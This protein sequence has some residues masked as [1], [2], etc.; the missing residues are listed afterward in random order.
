MHDSITAETTKLL[1]MDRDPGAA[2]AFGEMLGEP[3]WSCTFVGNLAGALKS[4]KTS[5]PCAIIV[6]TTANQS[7]N[8]SEF[9]CDH[10]VRVLRQIHPQLP[11]VITAADWNRR[12]EAL[13]DEFHV[14]CLIEPLDAAELCAAL[15]GCGVGKR[16]AGQMP[17]DREMCS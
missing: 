7:V 2:A 6:R 17:S 5:P 1:I 8:P 16:A 12:V 9:G 13:R 4:I 10:I 11:I 3:E 14:P 15:R